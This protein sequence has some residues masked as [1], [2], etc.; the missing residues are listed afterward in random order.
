MSDWGEEMEMQSPR[1]SLG[2]SSPKPP[3]S[4]ESSPP[5][6]QN[7][8]QSRTDPQARVEV[9]AQGESLAPSSIEEAESEKENIQTGT[10]AIDYS[11]E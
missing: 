11:D 3:S 6:D 5:Q 4:G 9:Q 7:K 2:E 10:G 1:S 8:S